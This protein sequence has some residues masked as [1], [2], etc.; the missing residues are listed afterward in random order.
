MNEFKLEGMG[1]QREYLNKMGRSQEKRGV[2]SVGE[3]RGNK[4]EERKY[5][6]RVLG[7]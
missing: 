5:A 6:G 2:R 4:S 3:Q 1:Y 7:L